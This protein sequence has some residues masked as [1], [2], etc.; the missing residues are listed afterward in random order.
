VKRTQGGPGDG[1]GDGTSRRKQAHLSAKVDMNMPN[2]QRLTDK[3]TMRCGCEGRQLQTA[4]RRDKYRLLRIRHWWHGAIE[5]LLAYEFVT[6]RGGW[7]GGKQERH[8]AQGGTERS[9]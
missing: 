3:R 8:G 5:A 1:D 4:D 7:H 2:N 9:S 6:P